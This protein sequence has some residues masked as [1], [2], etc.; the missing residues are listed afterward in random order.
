MRSI[1]CKSGRRAALLLLA[2]VLLAGCAAPAP[3][4]SGKLRIVATVFPVY[5][6]LRNVLG[7]RAGEVELT[8]LLQNG[9]DLHSYQPTA[10]DIVRISA[11]DLFVYVGGPSDRWVTDA[12]RETA[13]KEMRSISLLELLGSAVRTEETVEGMESDEDEDADE[14]DEHVWLSLTNAALCCRA[15][16][17]ALGE[18][19]AEHRDEYAANAAAYIRELDALDGEYRAAVDAARFDTLLF[20]DRF[21]FRYLTEDYGLKY[22]AAFSGCSA[23]TEASFDTVIF[24]AGKLDELGLPAI[25]VIEGGDGRIAQSVRAGTAKQDQQILTLDSMQSVTAREAAAGTTYLS[26]MEKNL[27]VLRRALG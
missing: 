4:E 22:Y 23:E 6:W 16:A 9:M 10:D 19:D 21:P 12:L 2:L 20:A 14:A 26:V 15:L 24:L 7:D 1:A 8:M 11:C 3:Q 17:D 5:D 25:L 13:N 27:E 18:L